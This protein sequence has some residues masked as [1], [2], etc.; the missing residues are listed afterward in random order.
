MYSPEAVCAGLQS[1]L[2][3]AMVLFFTPDKHNDGPFHGIMRTLQELMCGTA[4]N[5]L[6]CVAD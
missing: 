2:I 6:V 4:C 3:Y 5:G 1:Y